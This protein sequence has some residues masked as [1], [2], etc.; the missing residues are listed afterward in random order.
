[1]TWRVAFVS[2]GSTETYRIGERLEIRLLI[3]RGVLALKFLELYHNNP[4]PILRDKG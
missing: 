4:L 3:S 2:R 1:M